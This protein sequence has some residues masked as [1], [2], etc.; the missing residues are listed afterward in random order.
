MDEPQDHLPDDVYVLKS[1]IVAERLRNAQLE[2]L[3]A[4]LQRMQFGKRSEKIAPDQLALALED[5]AIGYAEA[6]ALVAQSEDAAAPQTRKRRD[7]DTP[8]A[9]LPAHLPRVE[10]EIMLEMSECPC[11]GGVLHRIGEDRAE[12]LDIIPA[13]YRVAGDGAAQAGLPHV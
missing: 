7:P 2:H 8:R 4:L 6:D 5:S 10:V 3:I 13:H 9:S 12:R 11:C 1:I